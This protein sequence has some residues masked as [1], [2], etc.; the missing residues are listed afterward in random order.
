MAGL[1]HGEI[2]RAPVSLSPPCPKISVGVMKRRITKMTIK[3]EEENVA[4]IL[5]QCLSEAK[6]GVLNQPCISKLNSALA[7][8]LT[9]HLKL[10]QNSACDQYWIDDIE[11]SSLFSTEGRAIAGVGKIWFGKRQAPYAALQTIDFDAS[12]RLGHHGSTLRI[13]YKL[14]IESDECAFSARSKDYSP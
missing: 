4:N 5:D 7:Y 3:K 9:A 10:C 1:L 6:N 12:F 8:L 11:W 13:S 14:S 2:G